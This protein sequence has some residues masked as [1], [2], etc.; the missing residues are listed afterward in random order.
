VNSGGF[1]RP[2]L[3]ARAFCWLKGRVH[4]TRAVEA[5]FARWHTG[6]R[7]DAARALCDAIESARTR[8]GY[9][10]V[11]AGV[12]RSFVREDACLVD[13]A[14][15]IRCPTLLLWGAR[16]PVLSARVGRTIPRVIPQAQWVPLATGHTPFVEDTETFLAHLHPFVHAHSRVTAA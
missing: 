16:D 4:I 1:A 6:T 5:H 9:A 10:E 8:P 2:D 7:T 12:W 15:H 14:H 13:Q 3:F 11:V